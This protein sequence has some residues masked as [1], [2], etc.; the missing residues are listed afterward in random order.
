MGYTDGSCSNNGETTAMAGSGAWFGENDRRNTGFR[1]P[2]PEQSNQIGELAAILHVLKSVPSDRA[3]II[4]TDSMYAIQGLTKNLEKWEDKGWLASKHAGVFRCMTAWMRHRS[5]TTQ[6]SW[7]KG[8]SG[9]RGN[10]EAD[11]LA[12]VGAGATPTAN[13]LNLEAPPNLVPSGA[14]LSALSQKDLYRGIQK[15]NN[16]LPRRT[17][18]INVGRVQACAAETYGTAPTPESV[19]K[20]TR[21]FL[22]KCMHDAF[23]IG[24]FW[25]RI[26]NYEQRGICS[27]CE[28]EESMEHILTEC[29]APGREQIWSL[30]NELWRKR[31]AS[32]LPSEYGA[33]LGSCLS[34]FKKA[35]GK[36]DKG[37]NRLFRIIMSES[38]YMI[39]KLRCERAIAWCDDPTRVHSPHE[40]HNKWLQ[41]INTRL[42]MDSVQTNKKIFKKKVLE[43]KR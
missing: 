5:N 42:R 9:V 4:R 23:K 17:S 1:V 31:S 36:P 8:H 29:S 21:E 11:K 6:I 32:D 15:I 19:W 28:S 39:W 22:W 40:I 12:A 41:A 35:N 27:K 43:A 2:G 25:S 16:P 20:K 13:T 33:I 24:K 38:V 3:L 30:A 37:L 18:E 10:E 7:V 26:E 14:K 34:G